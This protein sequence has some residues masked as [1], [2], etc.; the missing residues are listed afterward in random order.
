MIALM[1]VYHLN[2]IFRITF[3]IYYLCRLFFEKSSDF[4]RN[5]Y[6]DI[7]TKEVSVP[8]AGGRLGDSPSWHNYR[9]L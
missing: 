9:T 7:T 4:S 8:P 2:C 6:P 3:R 5:M 1:K